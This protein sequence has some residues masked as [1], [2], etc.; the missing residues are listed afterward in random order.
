MDSDR[1]T[2]ASAPSA[3]GGIRSN[4]ANGGGGEMMQPYS[5]RISLDQH[6]SSSPEYSSDGGGGQ[7]QHALV[8]GG[9][10]R[11]VSVSGSGPSEGAGARGHTRSASVTLQQ[12]QIVR[13]VDSM[14]EQDEERNL[15]P[16]RPA[17]PP[18]PVQMQDENDYEAAARA[19]RRPG[20]AM[21]LSSSTTT[22]SAVPFP[23]QQQQQQQLEKENVPQQR[24]V[25]GETYRASNG[26]GVSRAPVGRVLAPKQ[27]AQPQPQQMEYQVP[28]RDGS[29][30]AGEVTPSLTHKQSYVG[31]GAFQQQHQMQQQQYVQQ[32]HQHQ[33]QIYQQQQQMYQ[34]HPP[35]QP[36]P[37]GPIPPKPKTKP[38]MLVVNGIRYNR[39]GLL[40]K[41]GS[42]R[43]YRV[44]DENNHLLAIKR[45]D[46]SRNDAET[47][48]SF[49]NEI[50]LLQN[51]RGKA[52]IIQLVDSEMNDQKKQLLMVMEYG[53]T[54]LA[55][56]L[57]EKATKP[58]S[59]NFIRYIWEQMLEAVQV[60]HDEN[61]VH[62][63]LKPANFVLV[64]GRLKLIDFGI[65]K[66]IANDTTNIGRDSQIGTA[67]YMPPEAL[68]DSGMGIDGRKLMKLGRP[69]DVWALGCILYQMVYR[70]TP[71]A[72][73]RD[74]GQKIMAIQNPRFQI[75]FPPVS[76]PVDE[77]G[78][79]RKDEQVV[80]GADL[81]EAMRRCL[82]FD[83]AGRDTIPQLLSGA[84][85][86]RMGAGR[87]GGEEEEE[88]EGEGDR[89]EGATR[90]D[91]RDL[92][93]IV[94]RVARMVAGKGV[95]SDEAGLLANKLMLELREARQ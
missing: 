16:S 73:I 43:V 35:Q 26:G 79:Q 82:V 38:T 37:D 67:N 76:C 75:S 80:I 74:I 88:G 15:V 56:L 70:C 8:T 83:K 84:F 94:Q 7:Q 63:D 42:S 61:V 24:A 72:H 55:S 59:M 18:P 22:A 71:Y 81:V 39:I 89:R 10:R 19:V 1:T 40:G 41:G 34:Q 47:R 86:R 25:L 31:S 36:A 65:S 58:V 91:E 60:I 21:G 23:R 5:R 11:K 49:I 51:L 93:L 12:K 92:A 30:G 29:P 53:E 33:Q 64:K 66:T 48:A 52:Q 44:L 57:Q 45:V 2:L 17:P 50:N 20:S 85:L 46:I 69:A 4:S 87:I 28:L 90:V 14:D 9:L 78:E 77:K 54:D 32:Q 6:S 68:M 13:R 95:A 62:T 3:A 27:Q